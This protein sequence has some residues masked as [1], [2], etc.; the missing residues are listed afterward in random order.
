[1]ECSCL[2]A[3]LLAF[4]ADRVDIP[5]EVHDAVINAF[6]ESASVEA[7]ADKHP[8][9][10]KRAVCSLMTLRMTGFRVDAYLARLTVHVGTCLYVVEEM[11]RSPTARL[12]EIFAKYSREVK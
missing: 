4:H 7:P 1:M 8:L 9:L 6:D 3:S 2:R 10:N 12:E 5:E 11:I